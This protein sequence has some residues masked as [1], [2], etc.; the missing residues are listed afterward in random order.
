MIR[1]QGKVGVA[2]EL[3]K[4]KATKAISWIAPQFII[5]VLHK[6]QMR[7]NKAGSKQK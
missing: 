1:G 3:G 2:R 7:E 6:Q 5:I 4:V